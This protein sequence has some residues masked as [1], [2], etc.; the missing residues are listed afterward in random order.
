MWLDFRIQRTW[1]EKYRVRNQA[2]LI[3]CLSL[4]G[5]P[6]AA[7]SQSP[8]AS[9]GKNERDLSGTWLVSVRFTSSDGGAWFRPSETH[10]YKAPITF[11]S[12]AEAH[13]RAEGNVN[14]APTTDPERLYNIYFQSCARGEGHDIKETAP[15]TYR[16]SYQYGEATKDEN[17]IE[18]TNLY[19]GDL[20]FEL[21]GGTLRGK[22]KFLVHFSQ[23]D[24]T[25]A[26]HSEEAD[27]SGERQD[28]RRDRTTD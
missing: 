22:T 2:K 21:K 13:Y 1:R 8:A 12:V 25:T 14:P 10:E 27:W 16:C 11:T 19:S 24:G 3:L 17:G 4:L 6:P 20:Q 7:L 15:D 18:S 5:V 26:T 23:S 9:Q 28:D